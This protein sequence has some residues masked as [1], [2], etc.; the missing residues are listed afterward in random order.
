MQSILGNTR[1]HDL[2][3]HA[4]GRIDIA[5]HVA[6]LLSLHHGD[7]IDIMVDGVEWYLYVRHRHPNVGRHEGL[8]FRSNKKGDNFRAYSKTLCAAVLSECKAEHRVKLYVGAPT[9]LGDYGTALPIII[10][11]IIS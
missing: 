10:K 9:G 4:T 11:N 3:F 1:K 7:T 6:K 5:A 2:A 8:V